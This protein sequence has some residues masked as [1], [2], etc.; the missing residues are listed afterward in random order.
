M[1]TLLHAADI[2]LESPLQRL[3]RCAGALLAA[4]RPGHPVGL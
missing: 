3:E 1:L 2:H 4:A